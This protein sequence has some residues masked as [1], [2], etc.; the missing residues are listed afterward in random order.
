MSHSHQ[1]LL[2]I[3]IQMDYFAGGMFPLHDPEGTLSRIEQAIQKAHAAG[4]PI[5]HIQHVVDPARGPA[6]FFNADSEG[7][8]IHPRILAAAP[9]API[10]IKRHA[11]AFVGTTLEATLSQLGVSELFVAGMMTHNCVTHTAISRSAD[12][13]AKVSI[14]GDCCCTV[15]EMLHQ[16]ALSAVATRL[17]VL[18]MAEAF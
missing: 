16:I 2:L 17:Q 14:L 9:D 11:D 3:D 5:V 7:V 18:S 12:R 13:Y 15:S 4:M 1:A 8:A 10:V 6:P